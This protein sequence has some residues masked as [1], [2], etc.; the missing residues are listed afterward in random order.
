MMSRELWINHRSVARWLDPHLWDRYLSALEEVLGDRLTK[1]DTND[2]MRRK[3]DTAKSEGDFVVAFKPREDS[4]WLFG[5][6][7]NSGVQIEIRHFKALGSWDNSISLIFP[8]RMTSGSEIGQVRRV[9]TLGN[10]MMQPFYAEADLK[11]VICSIKPSTPSLDISRELPGVFW[12]TYFGPAYR[13]F[14]GAKF[15][16]IA[17][18]D[19][20][21]RGGVTLQ[22][23]ES[24][25]Q[26]AAS[27]REGIIKHLGAT[28][29]AGGGPPK[30]RGQFALTIHQLA[31]AEREAPRA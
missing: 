7:G 29:F 15:D 27:A 18:L 19:E 16:G 11:E 20:D 30:E 25:A 2:P 24:P 13:A 31:D 23:A 5:V 9:F 17:G 4:R 14:F 12:L 10:Q 26:V 1:L 22:L 3:A 8:E 28:S 21:S 6:F